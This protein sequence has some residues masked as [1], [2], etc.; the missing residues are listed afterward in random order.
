MDNVKVMHNLVKNSRLVQVP[1]PFHKN[2]RGNARR[3]TH[4]VVFTPR[5]SAI[6]SNYGLKTMLPSKLGT[7]L[8]SF[9]DID[10][11]K[12]IPDVE[13]NGGFYHK[14][15]L[16]Q[17][18]GVPVKTHF[19]NSNPL[20]PDPSTKSGNVMNEETLTNL[21]NLESRSS[22]KEIAAVL[23]RNP[24]IYEE[25]KS[26]AIRK[27]PQL[28]LKK[29]PEHVVTEALREF[30]KT[31]R[32]VTRTAMR[33]STPNHALRTI[34]GTGG[35]SYNQKGRLRNTP[36]GI[37]YN[38]VVPGRILGNRTAAVG[39]FVTTVSDRSIA[40]QS[41]YA[42][43]Q[44]GKHWRQ[45]T[46]PFKITE[47]EVADTGDVRMFAEGIKNGTWL[48]AGNRFSPSGTQ[49]AG[50]TEKANKAGKSLES[51]LSLILPTD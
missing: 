13:K 12:N 6:R 41:N 46:V 28:V 20:F 19:V 38:T 3:P 44:P 11:Y 23:K 31:S 17:E 37:Q 4:Q 48:E 24:R 51:L 30:L 26:F 29:M 2:I 22:I 42:K 50:P 25:F 36:N 9:N 5:A 34:Q 35:F 43:N 7:G 49:F 45:F 27:Y 21:L 39:G 15:K 1:T 32:S 16:F 47:A 10:N 40:L 33:L 14:L 18:M 8:I